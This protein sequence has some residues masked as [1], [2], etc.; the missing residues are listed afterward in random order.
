MFFPFAF[1]F[2]GNRHHSTIYVSRP[3]YDYPYYYYPSRLYYSPYWWHS[4]P[5]INYNTYNNYTYVQS[6]N[7]VD[8]QKA[9]SSDFSNEEI[10]ENIKLQGARYIDNPKSVALTILNETQYKIA[11]IVIMFVFRGSDFNEIIENIN[12]NF[13]I[14]LAEYE[15]KFMRIDLSGIEFQTPQSFSVVAVVQALTT[16]DGEIIAGGAQTSSYEQE[17]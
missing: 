13:N 10:L 2:H 6:G 15:K 8:L 17:N 16:A 14:P 5:D 12:Y 3:Y 1:A 11:G 9:E 7:S 4:S